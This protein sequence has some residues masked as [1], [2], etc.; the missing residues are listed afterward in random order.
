[1]GDHA[2]RT[3]ARLR[4]DKGVGVAVLVR[5]LDGRRQLVDY[6]K[7]P[8]VRVRVRLRVRVRVRMR[9][10]VRV[11]VR[12]RFRVRVRVRMRVRVRARSIPWGRRG[13]AAP[14]LAGRGS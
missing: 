11:R 10:R 12:V 3:V 7:L 2:A 5:Q 13:P 8:H 4:V 9:V 6:L 14:P 1:M